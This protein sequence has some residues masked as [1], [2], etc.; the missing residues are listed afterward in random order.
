ML[1]MPTSTPTL[2]VTLM[3]GDQLGLEARQAITR[4]VQVELAAGREYLLGAAAVA[5][6]L[7][8]F[9]LVGQMMAQLGRQHALGQHLLQLSG[10][11]VF[12]KD[13]LGVLVLNLGEQWV[14]KL[15]GER[16]CG[17]LLLG[18]LGGHYVG[19]GTVLS[20]LFHDLVPHRKSDRF[21]GGVHIR[22]LMCSS[23]RSP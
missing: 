4:D 19:H 13:R 18:L 9:A 21:R 2:C 15:D 22:L 20:A 17:F 5:V 6:V 3:L 11:A 7:A 8:A 16:V 1:R 10:Q 23:L 14:D 12:A